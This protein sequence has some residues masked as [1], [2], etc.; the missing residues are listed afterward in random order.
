MLKLLLIGIKDLKLM[1]RDRAALI[2]MLLAPFLLTIGLGFVTGRFSGGS[3]GLSDIPVVIVNLDQ[4]EL[5]NALEE[6]FNSADLADLVEPTTSSDPEAARR[7]I[8]SDQASAAIVIPQGFTDSVI[9]AEGTTFDS[10]AV[11]PAPVQIEVYANPSRPTGA[12]IIKAIVDEFLS[13]VEEG[14]VSGT[15]SLVGLMQS[16]LLNPQDVASEAQELFANVDESE[17]TAITLK[18][19]TQ[20]AEAVE[21]DLLAYFAPGMAL[22]FLMYTVSYGGRSIL[23]ERSQG[24]LPRML[25][26]PTSNA[27]VLG[28]KVLGIFLM[29]VAQVGVLILASSIFF[30]VQWGDPLGVLVL[31]LA[32]VFGATGWGMLITAFARTPAQVGSTGAA[33]MLIFGILGGSFMSLENFPPFMQTLSK[34][35]PNAWGMDGFVTLALGGTLKNLTE[36]VTALLIMGALLFAASVVLFNRNGIAQQ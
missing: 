18:T 3:T 20:G 33:V 10:T 26:S 16:G 30:Q 1:F 34:I 9:P 2:F 13:R 32:A 15:T 12:G 22:M 35:T 23:A 5:G 6:L 31:I 17:S 11:Q 24:T 29:G 25:I 19:D 28:G 14:R 7:L 21:F 36:P 4:K 27:Q 8:D